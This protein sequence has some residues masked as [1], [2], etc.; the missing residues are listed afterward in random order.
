MTGV[1]GWPQRLVRLV[2][3][4]KQ[5]E[6]A[7]PFCFS[8]CLR[9]SG[10]GVAP[11]LV[12]SWLL[13]TP[14][15]RS[16]LGRPRGKPGVPMSLGGWFPWLVPSPSQR[17]WP[18]RRPTPLWVES[19]QPSARTLREGGGSWPVALA[20]V[21]LGPDGGETG[22]RPRSRQCG[23][24]GF[25]GS[26]APRASFGVVFLV[27]G[28]AL[29]YVHHDDGASCLLSVTAVGR[30]LELWRQRQKHPHPRIRF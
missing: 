27:A 16:V 6:A 15:P 11:F 10:L 3:G 23:S 26:P 21:A 18:H 14:G 12:G 24:A 5:P 28:A 25:P 4:F 19:A 30:S 13:G 17:A 9:L 29:A 8:P 22:F 2:L 20:G 7:K 1:R